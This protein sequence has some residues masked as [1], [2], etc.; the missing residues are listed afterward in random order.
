M[1]SNLELHAHKELQIAGLF[2]KDSDYE[3]AL[4]EAVMKLI[5]VFADEG[6]SGFS[7]GMAISVFEKVCRFEP[8]TPLTGADDEWMD[9]AEYGDGS[10]CWQNIRCGHVFKDKNGAYDIDGKIFREP[11]GACFTN[12]ESRTPVTF[13]YTP[14]RVYVD[15]PAAP[16][17]GASA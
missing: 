16:D 15:V 3:G 7:A 10:P 1:A 17:T 2:D 4:G 12:S 13:P 5:K 14:T 11:N 8:L 6:H 9:I